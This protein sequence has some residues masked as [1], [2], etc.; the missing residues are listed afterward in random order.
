MPLTSAHFV[1]GMLLIQYTRYRG[2]L[3]PDIVTTQVRPLPQAVSAQQSLPLL[4]QSTLRLRYARWFEINEIS[5]M[6][7]STRAA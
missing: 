3:G 7:E 5:V 4:L 6:M 1:L 2:G